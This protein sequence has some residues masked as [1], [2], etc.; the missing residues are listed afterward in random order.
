MRLRRFRYRRLMHNI[1]TTAF[2]SPALATGQRIW[3]LTWFFLVGHRGRVSNS[4]APGGSATMRRQPAL[5]AKMAEPGP[6]SCQRLSGVAPLPQRPLAAGQSTRT[7]PPPPSARARLAECLEVGD[8]TVPAGSVGEG[9]CLTQGSTS[10][11]ANKQVVRR[12]DQVT[13]EMASRPHPIRLAAWSSSCTPTTCGLPQA[14]AAA[15]GAC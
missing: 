6:F 12:G 1:C 7:P 3:P 4:L 13:Y 8:A 2:R 5:Y 10:G 11:V 9:R 14:S 15:A